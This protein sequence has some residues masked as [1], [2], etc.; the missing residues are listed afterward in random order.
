[1]RQ[2]ANKSYEF[3]CGHAGKLPECGQHSDC[4]MWHKPA[5]R[6]G[7][8]T[9]RVCDVNRNRTKK[10]GIGT[11]EVNDRLK[12]QD[13]CAICHTWKPGGKGWHIDH[14]HDTMETRGILC[15]QCN[16]GLGHFNDDIEKLE[17]AVHY[18]QLHEDLP[19]ISNR[20]SRVRVLRDQG[21]W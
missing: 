2:E 20:P 5:G 6:K 10:Y 8:W 18:L 19:V 15:G 4:A 3:R 9:C 7:F 16:V 12:A 13:G 14:N 21:I 1:M 17:K 11:Y